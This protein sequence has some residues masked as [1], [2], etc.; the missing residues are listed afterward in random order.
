MDLQLRV[1][2]NAQAL[3]FLSAEQLEMLAS[4]FSVKMATGVHPVF[5]GTAAP[6]DKTLRWQEVDVNG[7]PVGTIKTFN[8]STWV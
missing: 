1:K 7:S 2:P 6:F 3:S 8:G 5:F 4:S